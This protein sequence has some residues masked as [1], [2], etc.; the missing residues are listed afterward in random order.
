[1]KRFLANKKRLDTIFFSGIIAIQTNWNE[2]VEN[3]LFYFE[4]IIMI[5][6]KLA[7]IGL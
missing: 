6:K 5:E 7:G 1:L 4:E 2:N 3:L